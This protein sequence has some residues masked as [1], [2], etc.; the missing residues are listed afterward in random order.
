[1]YQ[2]LSR[3]ENKNEQFAKSEV[4]LRSP[5]HSHIYAGTPF[6]YCEFEPCERLQLSGRNS[7]YRQPLMLIK[8]SA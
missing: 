7:A 1:L 3:R 6:I 5:A 8:R 2:F 4:L